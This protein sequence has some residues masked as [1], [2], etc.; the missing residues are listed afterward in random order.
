[1]KYKII[2]F[3]IDDTLLNTKKQ[4]TPATEK[5]L[6]NAQ[7]EG[8]KLVVAS[9]RLPYGVRPFAERLKV[10]ENNG[11][12]MGFNGGAVL[13]SRGELISTTYLDSKYI[14]PVY[15]V[16]RPL[17][18]TTMV[19][20]G[21][22]IY[23]DRKVNEYTHIE[24]EAV[25]LPLNPVD[26]IA[27]FVDWDIHKFLLAGDPE[28]LKQTEKVLLEKFGGE[29]DIY[30][31]AP[32]F[33]EVMPKG[34]NKGIGLEKICLDC[35]VAMDEVIAFGDSFNDIP[36]IQKAGLGVAMGNAEEELKAVAD[37]V[38]ESCDNDGIAA[39]LDRFLV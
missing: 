6:L 24:T 35:G 3:D 8:I 27:R 5:A 34:I 23:R 2:A 11:Y 39:A 21:D 12:Y 31:S 9:G 19:H 16:L 36:M 14:E 28:L 22:V 33:L 20:K 37:Y 25:G 10:L 32:W 15:D 4:L 13:N 38:T 18:I 17:N 1:M 26:D 7:S 30:L 29:V